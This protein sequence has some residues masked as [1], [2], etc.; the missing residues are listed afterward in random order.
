MPR[1]GMGLPK[2]FPRLK[3][4]AHVNRRTWMPESEDSEK[5][6]FD[7]LIWSL[8]ALSI[9]QPSAWL[10]VSGVKDIEN[11]SWSTSHRGPILIHASSDA[12]GMRQDR[13]HTLRADFDVNVPDHL[14]LGGIIGVADIAD[15][16]RGHPSR[17]ASRRRVNWVMRNATTLPF[18]RCVGSLGLF[19]P[20]FAPTS[21][22]G[23]DA[24][25]PLFPRI[26]M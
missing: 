21:P 17:W 14:P 24:R 15:C 26:D 1:L 11:R 12:S 10:V 9:R 2:R 16:V 23:D 5:L 4:L 20:T 25:L 19:R 22:A 7:D 6:A 13:L 3:R 8:P 18:R